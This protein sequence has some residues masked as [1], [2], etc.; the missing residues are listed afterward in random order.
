[1][2]QAV[3][4][5]NKKPFCTG[6]QRG[7]SFCSQKLTEIIMQYNTNNYQAPQSHLTPQIHLDIDDAINSLK[8]A[9]D[10]YQQGDNDGMATMLENAIF[11]AK[12]ARK[13]TAK[14]AA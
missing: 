2:T 4:T 5:N 9:F 10:A 14:K 1:M 8:M 11:S 13:K 12:E 6:I 7:F 3:I